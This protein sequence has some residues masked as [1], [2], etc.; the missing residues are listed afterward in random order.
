MGTQVILK[1]KI[2]S[3]LLKILSGYCFKERNNLSPKVSIL[4][5]WLGDVQLEIDEHVWTLDPEYFG[6]IYR[7]ASVNLAH[8]LF[9]LRTAFAAE[10]NIITLSPT[11]KSNFARSQ[12][13]TDLLDFFDEIGCN[14]YTNQDLHAKLFLSN[15]NALVGSFNLSKAALY[16]REEI[17]ISIDNIENLRLLEKYFDEVKE[18]SDPYGYT[19]I[20]RKSVEELRPHHF[21]LNV[22]Q[23]ITRGWLYEDMMRLFNK[24]SLDQ[25]KQDMALVFLSE[26]LEISGYYNELL[27]EISKDINNFYFRAF[28]ALLN[29]IYE[30]EK[31]YINYLRQR[32]GYK[33][34]G[35]SNDILSFLNSKM[36]RKTM[37]KR[38]LILYSLNPPE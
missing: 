35:N 34:I 13:V 32:F 33:G 15:D 28:S 22:E 17:G 6:D 30:N 20:L 3:E 14:I 2:K 26:R 23:K 1:D 24:L 19:A 25:D 11:D 37:P 7:I 4:T 12:Y 36:V 9:L 10:I 16:D 18:R 31:E 27:K 21:E 5:P 38:K 8:I 29:P